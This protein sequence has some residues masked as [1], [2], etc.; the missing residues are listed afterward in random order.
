ML[1]VSFN[2]S[3]P[4]FI[5]KHAIRIPI[6]PSMLKCQVKFIIAAISVEK[7]TTESQSASIPDA[8]RLLESIFSPIFR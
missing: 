6:I 1:I 7:E 5:I 2:I 8:T 4:D 3:I